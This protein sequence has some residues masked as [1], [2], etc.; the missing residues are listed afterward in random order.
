MKTT[1]ISAALLAALSASSA[2][3]AQENTGCGLGTMVFDGQSGI[4]PQVLAVT[5]NGTSGNQTFGISSGTLGCTQDGVVQSTE[6]LSMFTGSNMDKL[7]RDMSVGHGE[8]LETM[9]ELM[10]IAEEDKS[11]FFAVSQQNFDKIFSSEDVTAEQVLASLNDV[12]AQDEKLA[13]Y[14]A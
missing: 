2:F 5:T 14:T 3:A 1:L 7:A 13:R 6:K 12:M 11:S 8:S 9:A 4:G 10:G